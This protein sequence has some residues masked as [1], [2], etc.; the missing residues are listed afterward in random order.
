MTCSHPPEYVIG[1]YNHRAIDHFIVLSKI[2]FRHLDLGRAQQS[3]TIRQRPASM[4][5]TI[6]G[7]LNWS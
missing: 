4:L 1:N 6:S 7:G 2:R 5:T 3:N